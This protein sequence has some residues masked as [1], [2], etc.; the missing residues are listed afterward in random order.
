MSKRTI[1][2]IVIILIMLVIA[3]GVYITQN[4]QTT[5]KNYKQ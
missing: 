1:S 4:K 5:Q 2:Y 3:I